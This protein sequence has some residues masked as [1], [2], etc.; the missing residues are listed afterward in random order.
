MQAAHHECNGSASS[1]LFVCCGSSVTYHT[2]IL[3]RCTVE[4]FRKAILGC[5]DRT[6]RSIWP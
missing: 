5:V 4:A 1:L 3:S 6:V 2:C